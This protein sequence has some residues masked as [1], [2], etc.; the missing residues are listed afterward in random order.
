VRDRHPLATAPSFGCLTC[1]QRVHKTRGCCHTCYRKHREAVAA[2]KATWAGL[3]ARG[4][5]A[6]VQ[7]VGEAWRRYG[8]L[9]G[10]RGS[11]T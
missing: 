5:V 4:L 8:P 9:G 3:E 11:I 10:R 2:G 7:R 1:R 6:P